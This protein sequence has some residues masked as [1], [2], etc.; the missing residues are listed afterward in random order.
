MMLRMVCVG[1][2]LVI[3]SDTIGGEG[4]K[5]QVVHKH[6]VLCPLG[7]LRFEGSLV[8]SGWVGLAWLC[9]EAAVLCPWWTA[10]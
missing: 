9:L 8:G 6:W 5:L 3:P 2:A 10:Q 7:G 4:S 1:P